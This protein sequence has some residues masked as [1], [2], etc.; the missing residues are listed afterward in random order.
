MIDLEVGDLGL[1]EAGTRYHTDFGSMWRDLMGG[2]RVLGSDTVFIVLDREPIGSAG[3]GWAYKAAF[4]PHGIGW[5]N[6]ANVV[7]C[8]SGSDEEG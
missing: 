1:C 7:P 6:A 4:S 5:V 2:D 8:F 3:K